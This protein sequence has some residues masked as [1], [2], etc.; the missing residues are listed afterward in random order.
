MNLIEDIKFIYE[1]IHTLIY[2][3]HETP[4]NTVESI[5]TFQRQIDISCTYVFDLFCDA[6]V[7]MPTINHFSIQMSAYYSDSRHTCYPSSPLFPFYS[8]YDYNK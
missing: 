2:N 6:G 7:F 4:L 1:L 3:A 8:Q 5:S